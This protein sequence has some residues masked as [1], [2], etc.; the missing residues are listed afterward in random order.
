MTILDS[1]NV[2]IGASPATRLTVEGAVTLA[3]RSASDGYD[4]GYGQVWVKDNAPNTLWFTDDADNDDRLG[5]A[6][7]VNIVDSGTATAYSVTLNGQD[8]M[9]IVDTGETV[10]GNVTFTIPAANSCPAGRKITIVPVSMPLDGNFAYIESLSSSDKLIT[11]AGIMQGTAA[12]DKL[13]YDDAAAVDGSPPIE[14]VS[15]G[16]SRWVSMNQQEDY[17]S[18][19]WLPSS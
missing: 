18:S 17:T 8:H 12:T 2:G 1:G 16:V 5:T 13:E 7:D 14:L 6:L 19:S 10:G 15:D 11:A 4:A 9:L 3:E